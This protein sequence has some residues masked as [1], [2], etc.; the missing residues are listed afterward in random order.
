M[1][2]SKS[3][4]QGKCGTGLAIVYAATVDGRTHKIGWTRNL[5]NRMRTLQTSLERNIQVTDILEVPEDQ[6]PIIERKIHRDYGYLRTKGEWFAMDEKFVQDIF[7]F[8]RIRW[9]EDNTL[10]WS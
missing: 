4:F 6:A 2:K 9:S 3:P 1:R 5:R 7:S 8:G 10:E